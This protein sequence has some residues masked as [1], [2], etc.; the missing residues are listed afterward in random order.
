MDI[1]FGEIAV[2]KSSFIER[3]SSRKASLNFRPLVPVTGVHGTRQSADT[4]TECPPYWHPPV[5]RS[6]MGSR[7]LAHNLG[8]G[9]NLGV[10]VASGPGPRR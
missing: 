2:I 1:C 9:H 5:V 7:G 8:P 3:Y 10:G 6:T 4:G